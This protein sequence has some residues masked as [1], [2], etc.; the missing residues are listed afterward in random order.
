MNGYTTYSIGRLRAAAVVTTLALSIGTMS[1]SAIADGLNTPAQYIVGFFRYVQWQ[2]EDLLNN[3][4][5]CIV[6][7]EARNQDPTYTDRTVRGKSFSI[8]YVATDSALDDCQVLDLTA[9]DPNSARTLLNRSRGMP[10]LTV[11]S[12]S[13]FCSNGGQICLHLGDD[14]GHPQ[15]LEVNLSNIRESKLEVSARLLGMGTARAYS[16]EPR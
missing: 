2:D 13:D 12:G 7:Q 11:G 14:A 4:G 3:W 15:K 5:V 6:G 9:A 1:F 16:E 8:H 10:I